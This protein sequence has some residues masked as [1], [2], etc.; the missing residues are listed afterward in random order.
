[1]PRRRTWRR[2]GGPG[3]GHRVIRR[4][5]RLQLRLR[6]RLAPLPPSAA[7]GGRVTAGACA[8]RAAMTRPLLT[9][10]TSSAAGLALLALSRVHGCRRRFCRLTPYDWPAGLTN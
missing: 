7:K 8:V 9:P 1:M 4:Q 6:R 2:D 10:S 5:P 3:A